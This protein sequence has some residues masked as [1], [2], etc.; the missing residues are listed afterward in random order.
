MTTRGWRIPT[1]S[2]PGVSRTPGGWLIIPSSG[3]KVGQELS[4]GSPCL[5]ARALVLR[6]PSLAPPGVGGVSFLSHS[7][8]RCRGTGGGLNEIIA[9]L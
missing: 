2:P 5:D 1:L 6:G 4:V 8:L 3:S 9:S 7:T